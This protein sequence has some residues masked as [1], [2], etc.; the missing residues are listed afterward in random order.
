MIET[1]SPVNTGS[2]AALFEAHLGRSPLGFFYFNNGGQMEFINRSG[3]EII[4]W[5]KSATGPASLQDVEDIIHCGLT[6]RF[7]QILG[8]ESLELSEHQ[9]VNRQGRFVAI[10]IYCNSFYAEAGV[11]AGIFALILD[12]TD[13]YRKK[14]RLE[15][16]NYI[17]S[18]IS[19][20]SEA[21][22]STADIDDVLRVIL[23]GVTAQQGLGFNRAFLFLV[24]NAENCLEGK[25]AVGPASPEEAVE[26]WSRLA[27]KHKTLAELLNE[28]LVSQESGLPRLHHNIQGWKIPLNENTIFAQALHDGKVINIRG[29]DNVTPESWPAMDRLGADYMVVAP[30]I[31]KGNRLGLI[32]ADNQIT[33]R[34][35]A[36][37]QVE[38]LQTFAN[39]SAVAVERSQ[40]YDKVLER[41][42]ELAEKN[43]Q[44]ALSQEQIIR[45]E[46]M[47]VIG[48]LTSS[49]A[50][51]LRNPLTVIGGFANMML[52]TGEA[53]GNSEYLNIIYAETQRAESVIHQVL[54]FSRASRTPN[55]EIEFTQ[56][57]AKA[58]EHLLSKMRFSQR[59]PRF[60][61]GPAGAMVWGNPDQLHHALFQF[62]WLTVEETTDECQVE[63]TTA[64]DK[65]RAK[66][67]I[68]FT[69]CDHTRT[70]V[71]KTLSQIF[72]STTGTQKLSM[73]V[74]GETVRCHGGNY[75]VEGVEANFP[76]LYV[77]LPIYQGVNKNG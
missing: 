48:E 68:G 17:L 58:F 24:N 15:E 47:A 22:S 73:L 53:G 67:T 20:V 34:R 52:T 42:E 8:G 6:G 23:I 64:F 28:Y 66:M 77:E 27:N 41:A 37:S 11:T 63:I 44:L 33:G 10:N 21:V 74:A 56:M 5:D 39:H 45:S 4:G 3:A 59:R 7:G 13:S 57:T 16:T 61:P 69:G 60:N 18:V 49:I 30:V 31:S 65:D 14:V 38:L 50:H 29:R 76:S 54:D 32:I 35:I 46:K 71:V 19:Q 36:D 1:T 55:C 62:M 12:V 51:E 25:M 26:V 2:R 9:F 75:G 43:R 40:L 72:G 70:K